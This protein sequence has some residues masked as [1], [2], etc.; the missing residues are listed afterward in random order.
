MKKLFTFLSTIILFFTALTMQSCSDE[1]YTIW[2]D[3]TTYSEFQASFNTTLQDGYYVRVEINNEQWKEV[4]KSLTSEGRH[5][6]DEAT[7]KKWLISNGFGETEATKESS[8]LA[9][10][11]HG[12]L[13]TRDGNMVYMILK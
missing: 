3:S 5:R 4:S 11:N 1:K 10:V 9:L 6:W 7:I 13:V 2:T 8:W 12:L